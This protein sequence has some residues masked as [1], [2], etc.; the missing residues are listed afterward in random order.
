MGAQA[1]ANVP[2]AEARVAAH[3]HDVPAVAIA[4][5]S[6]DGLEQAVGDGKSGYH[7]GG[8]PGG[9]RKFRGELGQQRVGCAQTRRARERRERQQEY[10]PV[11]HENRDYPGKKRE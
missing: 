10:C 11:G 2:S 8:A 5:R 6:V 4:Q 9:H 7:G 3:K 1:Q